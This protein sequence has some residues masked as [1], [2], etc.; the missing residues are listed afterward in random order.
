MDSLTQIVLGAATAEAVVGKKIGNKALLLGAIA[1]TIPDLDVLA[2]PFLNAVDELVFHRSFSHSLLFVILGSWL[3]AY[4]FW[5]T[6]RWKKLVFKDLYLLFSLCFLTHILLDLCTTWGTQLLW[7]FTSYGYALYNVFVVD[8]F[9]TVPFLLLLIALLFFKKTNPWR[10]RLNWLGIILSTSYLLTGLFLQ[11]KATDVFK[12]NLSEQGIKIEKMITKPTPFNIILWSCS[13]KTTDGYYTGFYSFFDENKNVSFDF[14]PANTSLLKPFL[15]NQDIQTLI[16]VTKGFYTI[17]PIDGGILMN[18]LRF[19]KFNGWQG[20]EKGE[21]VFKYSIK[22]SS[23]EHLNI[24]Q[25]SYRK[26]VNKDYIKAFY[27]R[28]L[29]IK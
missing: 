2:S 16:K 14:E 12:K 22:P 25:I 27:N 11:K 28:V 5:K 4:L 23:K 6:F 1:G 13:V 19:G 26:P 8:P 15:K 9:Y 3:F 24:E 17:E 18:D 20:K 10:N 21:Y 7:P 29:G